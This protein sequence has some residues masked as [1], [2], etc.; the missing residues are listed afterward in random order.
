M[1]RAKPFSSNDSL[2]R[3]AKSPS[4]KLDD[5][6]QSDADPQTVEF[7]ERVRSPVKFVD[8]SGKTR[9]GQMRLPVGV[10]GVTSI[11]DQGPLAPDPA[12]SR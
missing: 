6:T 11:G 10:G 3:I 12:S 8:R 4:P 9:T 2:W 5:W 1:G 7:V